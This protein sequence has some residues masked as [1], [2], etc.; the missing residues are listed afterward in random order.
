MA[1]ELENLTFAVRQRAHWE[2]LDLG[3]LL[4]RRWY[5]QLAGLWLIVALPVFLAAFVL[6]SDYPALAVLVFWWLKPVYERMPLEYLSKAVFADVAEM[7]RAVREGRR[8]LRPGIWEALTVRRFS[9]SRAF[10]APVFVLEGLS[11]DARRRRIATLRARVGTQALW[12]TLLGVHVELFLALAV[13]AGVVLL[14]PSEVEI[15]WL[16]VLLESDQMQLSWLLNVISILAMGLVAPF[17]VAAGFALYLNRRVELEA[18]DIELGFRRLAARLGSVAGVLLVLSVVPA[19]LYALEA[20][21]EP[22]WSP[23]T[24]AATPALAE[25]HLSP[26]RRESREAI[27]EVLDSADFHVTSSY[28]YPGFLDGLFDF[29]FADEE[30]AEA[31]DLGWLAQVAVILARVLEVVLWIAAAAALVW[32]VLRARWLIGRGAAEP[33]ANPAWVAGMAVSEESLPEDVAGSVRALW[34]R[35]HPREALALLYRASINRLMVRFG[36]TFCESDT[37]N[38]LLRGA[39]NAPQEVLEYFT[40][41]TGLWIRVAYAHQH[42][43]EA[44]LERLLA[45]WTRLETGNA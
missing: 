40:G 1:L 36:C 34:G 4:G 35:S 22:Q 30:P 24:S 29:R 11:G 23:P 3:V 33:V 32:I 13:L 37:E 18:W 12:L 7:P 25:D 9:P 27:T 21:G 45:D 8:A 41:L 10:D 26:R 28:R 6:L 16:S 19:E 39:R 43:D 15:N 17:Y 38:D 5:L 14:V 44:A 2:A 31:A 20:P 42:P